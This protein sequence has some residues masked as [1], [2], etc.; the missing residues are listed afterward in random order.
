MAGRFFF[1]NVRESLFSN[2]AAKLLIA[3]LNGQG[4]RALPESFGCVQFFAVSMINEHAI[5]G[6]H[7][8]KLTCT[9]CHHKICHN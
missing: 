5:L 1:A 2:S 9:P 8:E 4:V 6:E 3:P 7:L